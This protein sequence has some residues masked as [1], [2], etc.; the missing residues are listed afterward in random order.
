M[1]NAAN[2][3]ACG[4]QTLID[5]AEVEVDSATNNL[6]N[7]EDGATRETV[8]ATEMLNKA[9]RSAAGL[10]TSVIHG[11]PIA[12]MVI[13]AAHDAVGKLKQEADEIVENGRARVESA[14]LRLRVAYEKLQ[15]L[16]Q[17]QQLVEQQMAEQKLSYEQQM[18]EQNQH[19]ERQMAEQT[20]H[21][22]RQLA[23]QKQ[24]LTALTAAIKAEA[25]EKAATAK[26]AVAEKAATE[27]IAVVEKAAAK[28]AALNAQIDAL[29]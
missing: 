11:A 9:V 12:D 19:F 23:D 22:E 21:F 18:A 13:V 25:D 15:L 2:G 24:V 16:L 10:K 29:K 8:S 5:T 7:V 20:Q 26:I 6:K 4:Q 17:M 28:I 27:K 14:K 1:A 3:A